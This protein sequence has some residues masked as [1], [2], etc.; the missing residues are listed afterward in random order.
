MGIAPCDYVGASLGARNGIAYEGDRSDHL[1]HFVCLDCGPEM[2]VVS[3]RNH[4]SGLNKRLLGWRSVEE[5][6]DRQMQGNP[7]PGENYYAHQARHS[8]RLNYAGKFVAKSDPDMFWINGSFGAREVPYLWEQ[9]AKI[10]CPIM[11]MKGGESDFLSPEIKARMMEMQTSMTWG[12]RPGL[13]PRHHW[14][15]PRLPGPRASGLLRGLR[16]PPL[17]SRRLTMPYR[18]YYLDTEGELHRPADSAQIQQA[19]DSW[20]VL[21]VDVEDTTEEDADLLIDVF[22]FHPLAFE[23]CIDEEGA[24]TTASEAIRPFC[25]R[26]C[27]AGH[28]PGPCGHPRPYREGRCEDQEESGRL[29]H[30]RTLRLAQLPLFRVTSRQHSFYT[31]ATFG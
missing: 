8:L 16:R 25:G 15:Q 27:Q 21:W 31:S 24:P 19:L 6:V 11:E 7:R 5:Y 1:K 17:R 14:R 2:S 13:R 4:I 23:R 3:A 12:R 28:P 22:G 9:W 18:S 26:S 30:L 20:G 10:E 29:Q